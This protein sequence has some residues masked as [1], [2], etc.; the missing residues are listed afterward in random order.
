MKHLARAAPL[1][2]IFFVSGCAPESSSTR[3]EEETGTAAQPEPWSERDDPALFSLTLERRAGIL[4]RSGEVVPLPWPGHYWPM[5]QDSINVRWDGPRSESPA[6]KYETAFR[7]A[8][9][10]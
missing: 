3:P 9:V 2:W 5:W 7:L 6:K 8:G 4:P 10:E 1:L